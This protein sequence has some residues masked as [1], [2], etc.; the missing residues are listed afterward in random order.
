MITINLLPVREERRKAWARQ[1]LL[2]VVAA[3]GASVGLSAAHH[4][5]YAGE[6]DSAKQAVARI[7]KDIDGYAPQ[8]AQVEKFRAAKADIEK[9][10]KVIDELSLARSG[11]VHLFDEIATHLPDRMW[12][13]SLE[14]KGQQLTVQGVS[15]D[16]ELVALFLTALN[17]SPYFD[18][19]ELL[20]TEAK[21]VDG[22]KLNAFEMS[23]TLG[24]GQ[25]AKPEPA[26]TPT[27]QASAGAGASA[28]AAR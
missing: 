14:V 17:A 25:E 5:W 27:K 3:V 1:F 8:L 11:P 19:V 26:A 22:Y 12:L 21:E 2:I 23:A 7:Q 16:N 15:L 28:L 6:V 18:N 20:E 10:L 24:N 13:T 4:W 9:K